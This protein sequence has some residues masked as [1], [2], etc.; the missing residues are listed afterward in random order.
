MYRYI[1]MY[2]I[3]SSYAISSRSGKHSW[4]IIVEEQTQLFTMST[5]IQ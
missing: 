4:I 2:S 1:E 5:E 3:G